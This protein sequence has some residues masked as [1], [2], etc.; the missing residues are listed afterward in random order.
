MKNLLYILSFLLFQIASAQVTII[1]EELP[2]D[3]PKEATIF[4]S[5]DFEGWSGGHK[6]YQ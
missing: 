3:T 1:I 5:G 4:I 6:D 2:K